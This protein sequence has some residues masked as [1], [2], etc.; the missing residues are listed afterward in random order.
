MS[1][2]QPLSYK[3]SCASRS[4]TGKARPLKNGNEARSTG[5][6]KLWREGVAPLIIMQ[7]KRQKGEPVAQ[8][9]WALGPPSGVTI[10]FSPEYLSIFRQ[11]T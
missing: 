5:C 7:K 10:I 2:P 11:A 9:F 8:L 4:I 1:L 6:I 3:V